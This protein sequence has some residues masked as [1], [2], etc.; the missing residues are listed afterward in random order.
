MIMTSLGVAMIYE[1]A[2]P[3]P[4]PGP[5]PG[6]ALPRFNEGPQVY[7]ASAPYGVDP[8]QLQNV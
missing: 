6:E 7:W 8:S 5:K 3:K 2:K 4:A 1:A